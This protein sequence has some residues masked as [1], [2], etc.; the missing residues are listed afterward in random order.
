[1]YGAVRRR[2]NIECATRQCDRSGWGLMT[3]CTVTCCSCITIAWVFPRAAAPSPNAIAMF[4]RAQC[5]LRPDF[6]CCKLAI[7]SSCQP[8]G[9]S[10]NCVRI[11]LQ[12]IAGFGGSRSSYSLVFLP[13]C[14]T[15]L[16][17]RV[18][19]VLAFAFVS[20]LRARANVVFLPAIAE[21]PRAQGKPFMHRFATI[22]RA[23][24]AAQAIA[25]PTLMLRLPRR[26]RNGICCT[27]RICL[28]LMLN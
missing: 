12:P 26:W 1:M 9:F 8:R 23:P 19:G 14:R 3:R 6:L 5:D 7:R 27:R 22:V 25:T 18:P 2:R 16:N 11:C 15:E 21:W 28:R 20:S 17:V 10:E 13:Q 24:F 4:G